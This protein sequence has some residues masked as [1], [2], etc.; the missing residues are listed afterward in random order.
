M[1]PLVLVAVAA[2]SPFRVEVQGPISPDEQDDLLEQAAGLSPASATSVEVWVRRADGALVLAESTLPTAKL[3]P[4]KEAGLPAPPPAGPSADSPGET[5]GSLSGKAV[6]MSQCHGWKWYDSLNNFSTQRGNLYDTV[7]DFHNPEGADQYLIRYLENAGARVYTVRDRDLNPAQ[8]IVD[9]GEQGYAESGAGFVDG[10]SG[11]GRGAPWAYGS[12]PFTTGGTRDF[13]ADGGAVATWKPAVPEDGQY[14]VYVSWDSDAANAPDAHYRIT[15]PAAVIDRYFD[16]RVHGSTWQYVETLWLPAG[17]G[18]LTVELVGDSATAG[19]T[20]SADAVRI[21]G[22]IGDVSRHGEVTDRPAWEE[23]G[24]LSTQRNGAPTSVYDP[25]SDGDG[26]DPSSRSRWADWEHPSG[27]DAVYLSWHSNGGGGTGT[28][29]FTYEGTSGSA[30]EGSW[31]LGELVQNEIVDAIRVQWDSDW[32]SRGHRTAAFSEVNPSHNNETPAALVELAFHDHEGDVELLKDPRFRDDASRAM[33]R[34]I[35]RYFAERDGLTAAFPPEPPIELAVMHDADGA[36]EASWSTGPVGAPWGDAATA[37]LV[38]TSEDGRSWRAALSTTDTSLALPVA[39]GDTVFVRVSAENDGGVSFPSETMGG[40]RSPDGSAPA[41]VVAAFDR[42]QPSLLPWEDAGRAVGVVRRMDLPRVNPFDAV[43]AHGQAISDAG[44]YWESAADERADTLD[45]GAW[46]LLVWAA[47]EES[48]SDESFDAAQQDAVRAMVG[49]G[50]ALWVS[51][52]EIL[53]DLDFRGEATDQQFALEVLG[54]AMASDD[55]QTTQVDGVALLEGLVL[56]FGEDAGGAYPVEYPDVLETDGDVI[57]TYAGG[58]TA[59]GVTDR[60]ALFGF[61]FET[62]GDPDVRAAVAE[63]LLPT[64]VPDY[65]PPEIDDPDTGDG[66][67]DGGNDDGGQGDG[68]QDDGG[69]DAPPPPSGEDKGGC[70]CGGLGTPA[71]AI[72]VWAALGAVIR[73]RRRY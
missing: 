25:Y 14:A 23:G 15:G 18:G 29:T 37:F 19:A 20:L 10:V 5:S 50:G 38:E 12:T 21:G 16:Q 26:S 7:E 42:L 69:D 72:A 35:I 6:Y 9:D 67:D 43:V 66:G 2:A 62:I 33:A 8:D 34:A 64:L 56:D 41:L 70:G 11:W 46:D 51:G 48:T 73:R 58:A 61:P 49:G 30:V 3:V 53:W 22:G 4:D 28:S 17:V 47:G 1:V 36:L 55:S 40:R 71:G 63:A 65:T 44:W 54:A 45:L 31:E 39:K 59:A 60:V 27:E 24:I 13:P 52:S 57:A 68:G 32:T